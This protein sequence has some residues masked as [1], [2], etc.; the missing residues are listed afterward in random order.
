MVPYNSSNVSVLDES[1]TSKMINHKSSKP[2]N[3]E[4][5]LS[6]IDG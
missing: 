2:S 5:S 6:I 4:K 3:M 1:K